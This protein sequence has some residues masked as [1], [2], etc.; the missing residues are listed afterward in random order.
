MAE[1]NKEALLEVSLFSPPAHSCFLKCIFTQTSSAYIS[2]LNV[3]IPEIEVRG[4]DIQQ[5]GL[6][7]NKVFHK[8]F[9]AICLQSVHRESGDPLNCCLMSQSAHHEAY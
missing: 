5:I 4:T 6:K 3:D 8:G 7:N 2:V 9:V 1:R